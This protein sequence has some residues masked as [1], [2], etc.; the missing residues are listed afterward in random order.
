MSRE[1]NQKRVN[2]RIARERNFVS[3]A[4]LF[5][6][7][8][9][10]HTIMRL[11]SRTRYRYGDPLRDALKRYTVTISINRV[12][13]GRVVGCSA[14]CP[15]GTAVGAHRS[16]LRFGRRCCP[17]FF[18]PRRFSRLSFTSSR[19]AR[20]TRSLTTSD[21]RLRFGFCFVCT[22]ANATEHS[23]HIDGRAVSWH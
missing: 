6:I 15:V 10:C 17:T 5:L 20:Q 16:F 3:F 23:A 11:R 22:T 2:H 21:M 7:R 1:Q 9:F 18:P 4:I 8:Y 12:A 13:S 19:C 14:L